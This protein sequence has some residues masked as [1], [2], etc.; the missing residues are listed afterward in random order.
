M[1]A[2]RVAIDAVL[3]PVPGPVPGP[4][5]VSVIQRQK[6]MKKLIALLLLLLPLAAHAADFTGAGL[7]PAWAIPFAG[8][9]LSIAI[10]PLFA[11]HFWH[12]HFGKVAAIWTLAL[13]VPLAQHFGVETAGQTLVHALLE[14]YLPFIILLA[15]LYTVAGGI[16]VHGHLHGSPRL[17]TGLLALGTVLASIMGTTG[18]AMLLIR[19]LIR[20]NEHRRDLVH[21]VVFF[22]FLVANAGGALSPLG[23][24]P[25]F[26]GFLN[27]VSFFW[28]TQHLLLPTL[29]VC[30]VLLA[31]FYLV[32]TLLLRRHPAPESKAAA[33][34][35]TRITLDG[36][37]NLIL[38]LAILLIVLASGL[39]RPGIEFEIAGT[40]V[41]LQNAL[42]EVLLLVVMGVSLKL[43]PHSARLG[44]AFN[45]A[46]IAEVAKL[47]AAIFI[48]IAPVIAILRAG[49]SGAFAAVVKL[50]EDPH[51]QPVVPMYFWA[52]GLLS[53]FLDNAPTYL[54][55]FNSA[56]G[57]ADTLM[58]AGAGTLAAISAGAVFMG[59]NSYIG[60][61]PNFMVKSIAE[62][63]GVRMPS[64]FGYLLWSGG[65]LIPVFLLTTVIFFRG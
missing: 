41:A 49:E 34:K 55:F 59:G 17:N 5:L 50:V 44:N 26:L 33:L 1:P 30:G 45:W 14:E 16:C 8:L 64:F 21:I 52:T 46:P 19:P 36:K 20:A 54:V 62:A 37:V 28:T 53:S 51:G 6:T 10:V 43:T 23:D 40:H 4:V 22:I 24:P 7:A 25:L 58:T 63:R 48:T 12:A 38:L 13:L 9:L 29:F 35:P 57:H 15:A 56:G 31:L 65:I 2:G 11:P 39:W 47:F 3:G 27:G 18:A 61:A 32:D 42:R 60:N